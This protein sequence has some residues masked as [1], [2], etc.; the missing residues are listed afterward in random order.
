[1]ADFIYDFLPNPT[2]NFN[3]QK[4]SEIKRTKMD[5]G[6]YLQTRRTSEGA[7]IG[8]ISFTLDCNEITI[9]ESWFSQEL[10]GGSQWFNIERWHLGDYMTGKKCRFIKGYKKSYKSTNYWRVSANV[11]FSIECVPTYQDIAFADCLNQD[12]N[13]I[14]VNTQLDG[15]ITAY[16]NLTL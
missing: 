7:Y 11:E 9:F 6:A 15:I 1:M 3:Y 2:V 5:S 16:D 4:E 10:K 12:N 13:L 8:S 14:T